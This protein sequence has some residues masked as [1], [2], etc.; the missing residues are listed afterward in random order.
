[1]LS[2]ILSF[3]ECILDKVNAWSTCI[4]MYYNK[5]ETLTDQSVYFIVKADYIKES[6]SE[7]LWFKRQMLYLIYNNYNNMLL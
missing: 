6:S 4:Y 3:A 1:M 7:Y 5:R 2:Y